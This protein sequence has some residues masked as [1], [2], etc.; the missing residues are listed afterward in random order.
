MRLSRRLVVVV[1]TTT[2]VG[3]AEAAAT[4]REKLRMEVIAP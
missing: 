3:I 2:H 1:S 4:I